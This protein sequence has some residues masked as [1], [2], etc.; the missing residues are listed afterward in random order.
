[1]MFAD[2]YRMKNEMKCQQNMIYQVKNRMLADIQEP[3][4]S[5]PMVLN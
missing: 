2:F 3:R 4:A 1:M 5:L